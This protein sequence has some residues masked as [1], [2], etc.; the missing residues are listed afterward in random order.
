[1]FQRTPN[2]SVPACQRAAR[3]G[4][5][6]RVQSELSGAPRI[7]TAWARAPASAISRSNRIRAHPRATAAGKSG[8]EIREL[9]E[10]YW[11]IGGAHFIGAIAD[12]ML[13]HGHEPHRRRLR[14]R[15]D[16]RDREGPGDR[17]RVVSD[18]ASDR[19]E[20]HLRRFGL[21]R[22]VQPANVKLVNSRGIPIERVTATACARATAAHE[23]DTLVS[24]P[25][26]TR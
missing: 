18:V 6:R 20:A 26:S 9:L 11:R 16:P 7:T 17:R 1:M 10:K 2:F 3:S 21:L 13:N 19:H 12:T 24:R 5:R 25:D 14:A 4:V 23:L 8:T 22:N 15:Q